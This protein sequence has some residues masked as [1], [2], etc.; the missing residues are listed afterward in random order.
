MD[1]IILYINLV[2]KVEICAFLCG[3]NVILGFNSEVR[4][5]AYYAATAVY[6]QMRSMRQRV[7]GVIFTF[8]LS[9]HVPNLKGY[10][11]NEYC[12]NNGYMYKLSEFCVGNPATVVVTEVEFD[13]VTV[14]VE[15]DLLV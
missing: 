2:I 10:K 12:K 3:F 5:N 6:V 13:E 8:G 7:K 15:G 1:Y 11:Y 4:P 9:D 14:E